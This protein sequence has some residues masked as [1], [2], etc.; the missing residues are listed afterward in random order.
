[1]LSR[2]AAVPLPGL[3]IRFRKP[4]EQGCCVYVHGDLTEAITPHR[5]SCRHVKGPSHPHVCQHP[6]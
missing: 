1:M 5:E 4:L 3:L 6:V 2:S